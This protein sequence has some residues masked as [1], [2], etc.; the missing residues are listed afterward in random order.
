MAHV[1]ANRCE[2]AGTLASKP[3]YSGPGRYLRARLAQDWDYDTKGKTETHRQFLQLQ[4]VGDTKAMAETLEQ[5][6]NIWVLAQYI[7]RSS[8]NRDL[9]E[10]SIHEFQVF[11]THRIENNSRSAASPNPPKSIHQSTLR[12]DAA[13]TR[14]P[15]FLEESANAWVPL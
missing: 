2:L 9:G 11:Q 7:R 14:T 13:S 6:D 5:G 1:I 12:A 15:Q 3:E 8:G 4:F 10:G